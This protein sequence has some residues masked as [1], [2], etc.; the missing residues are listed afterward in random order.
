[1]SLPKIRDFRG[2]HPKGFDGSGNFSFGITDD[3]IFPESGMELD[4]VRGMDITICS[5]A[6]TDNELKVF[7][8]TL[9]FP[10]KKKIKR[11]KYGKAI[12]DRKK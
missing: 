1:M 3:S 8:E 10:F 9:G 5:S 12:Y 11:T 6:K 2:I 4:K 7:M